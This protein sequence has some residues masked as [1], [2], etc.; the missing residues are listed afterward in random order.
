MMIFK[1]V[2]ASNFLSFKTLELNLENR[3]LLL[4]NGKNLD[5]PMLNNNGAGKSSVIESIVY[6]LYGKT[7]RGLKGDA[8]IH[9]SVG[10]NMK[11]FLDLVDDDGSSYR[12]ARYRKHDVNKNKSLL[13]KNGKDISPKSEADFGSHKGHNH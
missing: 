12:I 3:G 9:R 5:N 7:L 13:Y 8:V 1:A 2:T 6:A 10:K 4:L 11:V